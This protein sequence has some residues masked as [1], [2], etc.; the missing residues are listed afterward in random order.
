MSGG[1]KYLSQMATR[2]PACQ[3]GA[4]TFLH[5]I[6]YL[7]DRVGNDIVRRWGHRFYS[8]R[9]K[10]LPI[11][12]F[13]RTMLALIERDGL[14]PTVLNCTHSLAGRRLIGGKWG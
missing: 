13:H 11:L 6:G 12:E 8:L 10:A 2:Q 7:K 5:C 1:V 3:S 4:V 14:I 9:I